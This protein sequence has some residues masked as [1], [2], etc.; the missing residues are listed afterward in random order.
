MRTLLLLAALSLTAVAQPAKDDAAIRGLVKNYLEFRDRADT[1]ALAT[2]FV[3]DVDQLVSSGEWRKGREALVKGTIA[4]TANGGKRTL[5][6]ETIRY[7]APGAAIADARYELVGAADTR[8][9]WS[10]FVLVRESGAWK[11]AAIRN[12]LPAAPAK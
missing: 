8:R 11:I 2:I 4:S 3:A 9:M 10:T 6:V 12:M 7:I 1:A 5:T